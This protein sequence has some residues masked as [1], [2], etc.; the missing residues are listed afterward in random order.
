VNVYKQFT[1]PAKSNPDMILPTSDG[2]SYLSS[3]SSVVASLSWIINFL[4]HKQHT[5]SNQCQSRTV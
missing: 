3:S 2:V 5:I 1:T 4:S